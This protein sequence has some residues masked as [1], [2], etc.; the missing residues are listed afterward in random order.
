MKVDVRKNKDAS[1]LHEML[2][3]WRQTAAMPK[4]GEITQEEYDCWQYRYTEFDNNQC[5]TKV[6]SQ[7]LGDLLVDALKQETDNE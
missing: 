6:P 5:W 1:R 7:G 4:A 3:A 2:C